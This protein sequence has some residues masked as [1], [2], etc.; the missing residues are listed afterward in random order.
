MRKIRLDRLMQIVKQDGDRLLCKFTPRQGILVKVLCQTQLPIGECSLSMR[1]GT[2][3]HPK[4][5]EFVEF[6]AESNLAH[7]NEFRHHQAIK[8]IEEH[9]PRGLSLINAVE[10]LARRDIGGGECKR[11]LFLKNQ[12]YIVVLRIVQRGF[13]EHRA[14][15]DD[16]YDL[17]LRKSLRLRVADLLGDGDLVALVDEFRNVALG[18]M[19]RNAA[20]RRLLLVAAA[21]RQSQ[22]KFPRNELGVIEEHLIKIAEA[23]EQYLV[24]MPVL[25][26]QILLHH[27]CEFHKAS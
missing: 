14:R 3:R 27:R 25:R 6:I 4:R 5:K 20:H 17:A 8:L 21:A 18:G 10:A 26:F 23:K 1:Q 2:L 15:R 24:G 22:P 19:V 12:S 16:L 7:Q 9:L 11:F 13:C